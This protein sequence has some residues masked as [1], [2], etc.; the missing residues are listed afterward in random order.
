MLPGKYV[1]VITDFNDPLELTGKIREGYLKIAWRSES[2]IKIGYV[3][4]KKGRIVGS[5]VEDVFKNTAIEGEVAFLEILTA[6]K[7]NLVRAV[8]LYEADVDEILKTYP[9]A[10]VKISQ[11]E[12][13]DLESFLAL[14]RNYRG[15]IEI[16]DGSK[17]WAIEVYRGVVKAA[18]AIRGSTLS[19]DDAVRE[20]LFEM[21]HL[22][23]E[24]KYRIRDSSGFSPEDTVRDGRL[25]LEGVE[26]LKEKQRFEKSF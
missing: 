4:T 7:H 3:L 10:H 19:G 2:S 14:L 24:G 20:I 11:R 26:L 21:G 22:L 15:E 25:L 17:A 18:R 9:R 23:K 13:R 12:G 6:I 16:Q 8:E 1:G 5:I